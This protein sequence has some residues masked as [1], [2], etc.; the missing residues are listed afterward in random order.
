M[1]HS[2]K[3]ILNG[4][5]FFDSLKDKSAYDVL[6][7]VRVIYDMAYTQRYYLISIFDDLKVN[8]D[9]VRP[10]LDTITTQ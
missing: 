6:V 10:G 3:N 7:T 4:H 8:Y 1:S 5:Q 2:T 9:R